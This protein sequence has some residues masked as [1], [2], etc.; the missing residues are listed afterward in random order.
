MAEYGTP[1]GYQPP[2][3]KVERNKAGEADEATRRRMIAEQRAA[4][5]KVNRGG[6]G[7]AAPVASAN[8]S[9]NVFRAAKNLA[10]RGRQIEDAIGEGNQKRSE[11]LAKALRSGT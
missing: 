6:G 4:A 11:L 10:G 7:T 2:S 5:I 8:T 1:T 3:L 9:S